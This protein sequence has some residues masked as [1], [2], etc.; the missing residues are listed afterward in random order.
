MNQTSEDTV[1]KKGRKKGH[2]WHAET[3][4]VG[5]AG[6]KKRFQGV[7]NVQGIRDAMTKNETLVINSYGKGE[8]KTEQYEVKN[9]K[10]QGS[11]WVYSTGIVATFKKK[12]EIE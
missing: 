2:D 4:V 1:D 7:T 11:R 6:N 12:T 8:H 9:K 10:H 3:E 5:D